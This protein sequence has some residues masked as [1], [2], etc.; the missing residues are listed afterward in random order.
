MY[1]GQSSFLKPDFT[2]WF[3]YIL[4]H[5]CCKEIVWTSN[6]PKR[7][8]DVTFKMGYVL[9]FLNVRKIYINRIIK[10]FKILN[11]SNYRNLIPHIVLLISW[12][13]DIV[14]KWSYGSHLSNEICI[15]LVAC[16]L[17]GEIKQKLHKTLWCDFFRHPVQS[18]SK[19]NANSTQPNSK[20]L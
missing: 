11:N 15:S 3:S 19:P 18:V 1:I 9:A 6:I 5:L 14:Q 13:P 17:A 16:L 8:K 4:A 10:D 12:L 2:Y 7:M 20:K